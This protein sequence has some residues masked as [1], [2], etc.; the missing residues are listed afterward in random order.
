MNFFDPETGARGAASGKVILLGEH[1]VVYGEP[2]LAVALRRGV[3]ACARRID[4]PLVLRAEKWQL[5]VKA[6]DVGA[7]ARAVCAL[8]KELGVDPSGVAVDLEPQIPP[9]AGLGASA[10]MAVAVARSLAQFFDRPLPDEMLQRAVHAS[11]CV[12]HGSPSGLDAAVSLTGESLLFSKSEGATPISASV[13]PLLVVHSGIPKDTATSVARFAARM[14][15]F[16]EESSRRIAHIGALARR[17]VECLIQNDLA[18]LGALMTENHRHL[19]WFDVSCEAL[20]RI[21][22]LALE[23]GALGAK[24]TGGGRGGCAVIL[25]PSNPAP[26]LTAVHASGFKEVFS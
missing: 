19:Q 14:K 1:A 21:V 7:P 20:D 15:E 16:P 23:A 11:E 10:A 9:R 6:D 18:A 2:A 22:A 3:T 17:G 12:F 13:P 25:L 24:L 8:C 26:V 5:W 4:G